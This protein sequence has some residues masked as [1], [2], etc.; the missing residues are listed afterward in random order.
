MSV[1]FTLPASRYLPI[2]FILASSTSAFSQGNVPI[3]LSNQPIITKS[4]ADNETTTLANNIHQL[5]TQRNGNTVSLFWRSTNDI[6][7]DHFEIERAYSNSGNYQIVGIVRPDLTSADPTYTY[8][9]ILNGLSNTNWYRL[10]IVHTNGSFSY[11]PDKL[12]E[13]GFKGNVSIYPNPSS[14][15]MVTLAFDPAFNT[16]REIIITNQAGFTV[17]QY[18]N[19]SSNQLQVNNLAKGNYIVRAIDRLGGEMEIGKII[20][21]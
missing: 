14:T 6:T 2:F 13:S 15:G 3:A 19:V 1:P 18:T 5:G 17:K 16:F 20:V 8:N 12:L 7:I 11:S 10:K 4:R 9:D 21:R